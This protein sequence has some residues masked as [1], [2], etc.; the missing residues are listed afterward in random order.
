[1]HIP[2]VRLRRDNV[3]L[4][5]AKMNMSA[6]MFAFKLMIP[7]ATFSQYMTGKRVVSPYMRRKISAAFR[8]Y[9][10][11]CLYEVIQE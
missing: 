1:M 6:S 3:E 5:L 7:S 2:R 11:D 9:P 8:G 4:A 10:W